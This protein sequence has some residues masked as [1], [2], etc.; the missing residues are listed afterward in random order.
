MKDDSPLQAS[1][2]MAPPAGSI[3]KCSLMGSELMELRNPLT[4][5]LILSVGVCMDLKR[6]YCTSENILFVSFKMC[7]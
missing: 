7:R 3:C 5:L 6:S 2:G 1:G 4:A